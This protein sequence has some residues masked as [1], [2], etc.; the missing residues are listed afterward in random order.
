MKITYRKYIDTEPKETEVV[1]IIDNSIYDGCYS[2][3]EPEGKESAITN[4][5]NI[6]SALIDLLRERGILSNED[7]VTLANSIWG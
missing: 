6:L 7:I 1:D 5:A 2:I 4:T 3:E